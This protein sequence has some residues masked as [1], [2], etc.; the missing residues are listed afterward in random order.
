MLHD[1][2]Q[3]WNPWN[4]PTG[5]EQA[6][7]GCTIV[8]RSAKNSNESQIT[9]L[10]ENLG[11]YKFTLPETLSLKENEVHARW[12]GLMGSVPVSLLFKGIQAIHSG[13]HEVHKKFKNP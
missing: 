2:E 7:Q 11:G 3:A 1:R 8:I 10:S 12:T 9:P 4:G 5:P 6:G 13:T